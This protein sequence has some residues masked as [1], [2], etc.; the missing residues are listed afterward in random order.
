[1]YCSKCGKPL[2][3]DMAFCI[4]CGHPAAKQSGA[5]DGT[6]QQS[7]NAYSQHVIDPDVERLVGVKQEY[8]LPKFRQFKTLNKYASW[9][10]SAFFCTLW[11]FV[12]RKMYLY[13]LCVWGV[14]ILLSSMTDGAGGLLVSIL[15]GVF[16]NYIYMY[17][18]EDQAKQAKT[19]TFQ[20][21]EA[22]LDK[23]SGVN[24]GAVILLTIVFVLFIALAIFLFASVFTAV[25]TSHYYMG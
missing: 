5:D 8:Y 21:K 9:N 11:W 19:M 13:A 12:Y 24:K 17:H 20:E 15:S 3:E 10:W 7:C 4:N 2:A 1:M 25:F 18:L 6:A 16:G 23:K 14:S 22:F